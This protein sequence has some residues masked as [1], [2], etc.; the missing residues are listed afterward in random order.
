MYSYD[1]FNPSRIYDWAAAI[2]NVRRTYA[3]VH[4]HTPRLLR[5]ERFTEK[6]QWRKLFDLN[7]IYAILSDKL[8]ARDFITERVG[9]DVLVP[10]LWVGNDPDAVPF[11]ALN[12][13]YVVKS[14]HGWNHVWFVRQREDVDRNAAVA[15]FRTWLATCHGTLLNEPGYM[16]VPRRLMAEQMLQGTDGHPP[17]ERC[18][19]V[20]DGR[21][22][23]VQTRFATASRPR[24]VAYHD[25]EWHPLDWYLRT[26]N[27]PELCPRPERLDDMI[28][29]AECLGKGFD[30]LRVDIYDAHDRIWVGELTLY[31]WSGLTPFCSDE[32]DRLV[33]SY[34]PLR[35]PALRSFNAVLWNRWE[36]R[37]KV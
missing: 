30:H 15:T 18:L 21:V 14:T 27:Q 32:A 25:P 1:L 36:I 22:R 13:P 37:R 16:S 31:S 11:D 9:A 12:P 2:R 35:H 29:L 34:W 28:A 3:K 10:I 33:G 8:A 26:P 20:F 23:F 4:G 19:F 6:M 5:P 7:P 24:H 17:T